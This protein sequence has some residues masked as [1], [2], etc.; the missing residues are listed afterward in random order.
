M[1]VS[2]LLYTLAALSPRKRAPGT[3]QMGG[4]VGPSASLDAVSKI[5][6]PSPHRDLSRDHLIV[7]LVVNCYTD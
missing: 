4:W 1:E 3:H 5:T 7:Q 2:G 6:I